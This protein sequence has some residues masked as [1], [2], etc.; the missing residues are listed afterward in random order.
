MDPQETI[1]LLDELERLGFDD[2]S[3]ALLH[4]FRE[5]GRRDNIAAHRRYCERATG[6]F[7]ADF[8]NARTQLRL[9]YVLEAYKKLAKHEQTPAVF[10]RLANEAWEKIPT[11]KK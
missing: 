11:W 4:H 9:K 5:Q 3:F 10:P 2:K 8:N 7:K 1:R 6:S